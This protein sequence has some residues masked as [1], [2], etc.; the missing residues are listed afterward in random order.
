MMTSPQ[1]NENYVRR[2]IIFIAET[3][4]RRGLRLEQK[5]SS[6]KKSLEK[7]TQERK[8]ADW[9]FQKNFCIKK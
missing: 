6:V 9:V 8:A 7:R 5:K 2:K 4:R 1:H 3:I